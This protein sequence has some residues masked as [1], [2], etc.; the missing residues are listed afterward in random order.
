[1]ASDVESILNELIETSKDGENGFRKAGQDARDP[2]LKSLFITCATRCAEGAR[3]LQ[4]AVQ[5]NG[6]SSEQTGSV[7]AALH[8][9]WIN[10]REAL[11]TRD[12]TAIL[13]ECERGEDYAKAQYKKAL[14]RDLPADVRSIVQRQYQGVMANHDKVRALRDAHR[15]A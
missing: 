15:V 12:D 8:R 11:T 4:R 5:A 14:E 2:E 10:V 6:G 13:E 9:G 7:A 3:E 1:M